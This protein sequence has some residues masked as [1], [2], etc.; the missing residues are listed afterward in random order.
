MVKLFGFQFGRANPDDG[1]EIV[2]KM[3]PFA[4]MPRRP[5]ARGSRSFE[6]GKTDRLVE[7]WT[8]TDLTMNQAMLKDLRLMRARSRD[9][10]RN[11]EFGRKFF[12]LVRNNVVGPAGFT[13]KVDARRE[14]GSVDDADSKVVRAAYLR[15]AKLGQFDVTGRLSENQF[16]ALAVQM[17]ARDGEVLIRKVEGRDRGIH[18]CQ[19][20][21]LPAHLLDEE[22]NRDLA[23]GNRIRM[24]VEFDGWM[25]P[26]A[27][28]LRILGQ[29]ADMHGHWSQRYDRVAADEIIHLF[30]VED[31][32]QWRGLPWA[33]AAMRR[34]RQLDQFDE[35]ALVAANVGASKMGFFQQK[36]PEAGAPI[37]SDDEEEG[38]DQDF[39]S[40][41]APGQFDVIPDGYELQEWD[42]EYPHA[43]YDPFVKAI[44]RTLSTGLLVSYHGLTGDLTQ[45]NFSSIRSGT[46]DEREM[47]KQLQGWYI[48][49]VKEPVF[50]WWLAHALIADPALRRLPFAKFDKF[51]SPVF[52]GRRWDWVDPAKDVR[53]DADAVALGIKSRAQ[54]IRER[55]RD[56]DEVWAELDQEA[57]RGLVVATTPPVAATPEQD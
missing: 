55:G 17:V 52:F 34:A 30:I 38:E 10:A 4:R 53:A 44:A 20:Q 41:A 51:N 6:V 35:A 32:E 42:P 31:A 50:S 5:L 2:P 54:I 11:N 18:S 14:D 37:A 24:G 12:N 3:P 49:T 29:S 26:V 57:E 39:T 16:D 23:G 21:L 25:K 45:V 56:P 7:S 36:D 28:W 46:L 8:R 33:Y 1:I 48:E 9:F 22:L 13:L 19:L 27:Y 40:E 15:W 47:W 43:V